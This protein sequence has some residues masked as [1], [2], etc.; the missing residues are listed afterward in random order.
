MMSG[1]ENIFHVGKSCENDVGYHTQ[2]KDGRCF[3]RELVES[4]GYDCFVVG[5]DTFHTE[6]RLEKV[7]E[8]NDRFLYQGGTGVQDDEAQDCH[9]GSLYNGLEI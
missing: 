1:Q 7:A 2:R 5:D 9:D 3:R 8:R 4:Y 6:S